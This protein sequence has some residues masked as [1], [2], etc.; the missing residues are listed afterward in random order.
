MIYFFEFVPNA[1][2]VNHIVG[3][4][5]HMT[6]IFRGQTDKIHKVRTRAHTQIPLVFLINDAIQAVSV[7]AIM[8]KI[9]TVQ[10]I[11]VTSVIYNCLRGAEGKSV[12]A[13]TVIY[14]LLICIIYINQMIQAIIIA[15]TAVPDIDFG[16]NATY[17]F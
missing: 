3:Q 8:Q 10:M 11:P 16:I 5:V 13:G 14:L 17:T 9:R 6:H 4:G 15:N 12:Y 2:R 7:S 1:M